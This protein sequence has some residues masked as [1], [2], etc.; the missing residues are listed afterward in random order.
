[1]YKKRINKI[2]SKQKQKQKQSQV[3]N[4]HI[5]KSTRKPRETPS[6]PKRSVLPTP[7][8]IYT[9][10]TDNLVPQMFNKEGK[11]EAMP[12]LSE[13]INKSLDEKINKLASQYNISM[14]KPTQ[15]TQEQIRTT[16]TS[17]FGRTKPFERNI[18]FNKPNKPNITKTPIYTNI[19][20]EPIQDTPLGNIQ[21]EQP[22]ENEPILVKQEPETIFNTIAKSRS[23]S[24]YASEGGL[25]PK[26]GGH[27]INKGGGNKSE[28]EPMT[29]EQKAKMK[30]E[31][32]KSFFPN[33]PDEKIPTLVENIKPFDKPYE[34]PAKQTREELNI[35]LF[36]LIA[37]SKKINEKL[38]KQE[39]AKQK[40]PHGTKSIYNDKIKDYKSSIKH[41]NIKIELLEK[42]LKE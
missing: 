2:K 9:S 32:L 8:Y 20:N 40:A 16:R 24:G 25:H 42:Q 17:Q 5:H 13:Q 36:D 30:E 18:L 26:S 7:Q 3:V 4:V 39:A 38:S 19:F 15:P 34:Q 1:M 6:Q 23:I 29:Q 31:R 11:Q 21:T 41:N 27:I 22:V 14:T 12:S 33:K 37:K 10:Q 28:G 35:K